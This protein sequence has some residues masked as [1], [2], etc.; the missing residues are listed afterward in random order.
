LSDAELSFLSASRLAALV[1]DGQLSPVDLADHFIERVERLNPKLN[2]FS[3]FDPDRVRAEARSAENAILKREPLGPL[4]GVPVAI[5]DGIPVKDMPATWGSRLMRDY[6]AAEDSP[7]A[8]RLRNAGAIVLGKT[9]MPEFGHKGVTDSVLYGVTRNPHNLEHSPGGSTGGGAAAVAAGLAPLAIGTDGGGSVRIPASF[10]GLYCIKPA[11]GRIP[12]WPALTGLEQLTSPGPLANNVADLALGMDVVSGP[13]Y[14]DLSTLPAPTESYVECI[15][16]AD[17]AGLRLA[18][19]P[20]LG[21]AAVDPEVAATA[22]DAARRFEEAGCSIEL[23]DQPF[24]DLTDPWYD[25][26]CVGFAAGRRDDIDQNPD[27]LD[28]SFVA[29]IEHGLSL[30][31]TDVFRAGNARRAALADTASVFQTFDALLLPTVAVPPLPLGRNAIDPANEYDGGLRE[32]GA[33][34]FTFNMTGHPAASVPAG[35][36]GDNL[37]V[38]LQIV[39]RRHDEVTVLRL[40]KAFEDLSGPPPCPPAPFG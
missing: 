35:F 8:A 39:G 6:V 5:K 2:A 33:L 32:W 12:L 31:G 37:P 27:L 10:T 19:T 21:F 7:M 22:E 25:L 23:L 3:Y 34:T 24:P 30:S 28:D 13:T 16:D 29:I 4:H 20:D 17:V 9:T 1:R 18:W 36:V 14:R 15:E 38:G 26:F 11:I 40:A